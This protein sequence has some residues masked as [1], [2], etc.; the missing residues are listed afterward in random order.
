[1]GVVDQVLQLPLFVVQLAQIQ[2]LGALHQLVVEEEVQLIL[3]PVVALEGLAVVLAVTVVLAV[4]ELQ[5]KVMMEAVLLALTSLVVVA[6][7]REVSA[8]LVSTL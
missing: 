8:V 2:V 1:L 4:Q 6:V 7:D 3:K 5:I